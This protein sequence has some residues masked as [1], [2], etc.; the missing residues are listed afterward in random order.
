[1]VR[2]LLRLPEVISR[3]GRSRSAIY[4]DMLS[5]QFPKSVPIGPNARGWVESEV[6][7]F[8]AARIAERDSAMEA[9]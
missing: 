8:I 9:A 5:G 1:M 7:A 3:T 2:R 4:R 6:D